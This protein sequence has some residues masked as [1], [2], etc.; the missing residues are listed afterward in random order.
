MHTCGGDPVRIEQT[1]LMLK[2]ASL[3]GITIFFSIVL[4]EFAPFNRY[5]LRAMPEVNLYLL[6]VTPLFVLYSLSLI[7]IFRGINPIVMLIPMLFIHLISGFTYLITIDPVI[8]SSIIGLTL[9]LMGAG[10]RLETLINLFP[11]EQRKDEKIPEKSVNPPVVVLPDIYTVLV[12]LSI[13]GYCGAA[14]L[15]QDQPMVILMGL[16]VLGFI[17]VLLLLLVHTKEPDV[18]TR[19]ERHCVSQGWSTH[20]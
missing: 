18:S 16:I 11:E 3:T 19:R 1:I 12:I 15:L 13:A 20:G 4:L 8:W 6:I 14:L 5:Y 17:I 7:L 9:F 2:L 10:S